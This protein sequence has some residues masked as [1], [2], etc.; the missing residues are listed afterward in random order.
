M[1]DKETRSEISRAIAKA[2]A[3]KKRG[4]QEMTDLWALRLLELLECNEIINSMINGNLMK[5]K[6][7]KRQ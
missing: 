7:R 4:N 1:I 5:A 6:A 2:I 3:Y